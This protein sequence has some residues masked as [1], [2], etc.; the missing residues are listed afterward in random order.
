M[1][2]TFKFPSQVECRRLV[3][4]T[5]APKADRIAALYMLNENQS[6]TRTVL[7]RLIASP[8]GLGMGLLLHVFTRI[9]RVF[10]LEKIQNVMHALVLSALQGEIYLSPVEIALAID[11][12]EKEIAPDD[13]ELALTTAAA[14]PKFRLIAIQFIN[15]VT[16]DR[17]DLIASLQDY[18]RLFRSNSEIGRVIAGTLRRCGA[19]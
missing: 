7:K 18:R 17:P 5:S 2:K 4:D 10:D 16:R 8:N 19:D 6:A 15:W 1:K 14:E 11:L 9:G 3:L 13:L 12:D